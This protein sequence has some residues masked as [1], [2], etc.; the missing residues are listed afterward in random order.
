MRSRA[1]A[2]LTFFFMALVLAVAPAC[3]GGA[4]ETSL[5]MPVRP[6]APGFFGPGQGAAVEKMRTTLTSHWP[7]STPDRWSNTSGTPMPR[8]I[9]ADKA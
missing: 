1:L 8:E 7:V 4:A 3:S 2:I 9:G 5:T 6:D